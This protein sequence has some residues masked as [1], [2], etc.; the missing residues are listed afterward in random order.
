MRTLLSGEPRLFLRALC[1]SVFSVLKAVAIAV[2]R[3]NP[4]NLE[5]FTSKL[6][7]ARHPS[8]RFWA[9]IRQS[10]KSAVVSFQLKR[11]SS[12]AGSSSNRTS[13]ASSKPEIASMIRFF[14]R[15]YLDSCYP[16]TVLTVCRWPAAL[17]G[18]PEPSVCYPCIAEVHTGEIPEAGRIAPLYRHAAGRHCLHQ[19]T[20]PV[21][22]L[23]DRGSATHR[24]SVHSV[25]PA[26]PRFGQSR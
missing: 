16:A 19:R 12:M 17:R 26:M 11:A 2:S 22:V 5:A 13:V 23:R 1:G 25:Q 24:M 18:V 8:R 20:S 3:I 9:P 10:A 15:L 7:V 6:A 4:G 21:A 14:G